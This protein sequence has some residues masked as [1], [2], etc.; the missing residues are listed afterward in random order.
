MRR[1][2]MPFDLRLDRLHTVIQE[3]VGC[4]DRHLYEFR[5]RNIGFEL[6]MRAASLRRASG[7]RSTSTRV[8][9]Q[10]QAVAEIQTSPVVSSRM[11]KRRPRTDLVARDRRAYSRCRAPSQ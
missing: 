9:S 3:V 7:T 2:E 5:I 11:A 6:T 10:I 8:W 4:T 1:V